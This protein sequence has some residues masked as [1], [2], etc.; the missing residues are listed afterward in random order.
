MSFLADCGPGGSH[1]LIGRGNL[2]FGSGQVNSI[3]GVIIQVLTFIEIATN[4]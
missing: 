1:L 2:G 3:S 4:L